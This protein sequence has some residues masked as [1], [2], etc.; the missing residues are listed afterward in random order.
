[1]KETIAWILAAVW[2]AAFLV[3]KVDNVRL[4]SELSKIKSFAHQQEV[5]HAKKLA[6]A[7]DSIL[8]A[9]REYDAVRSERDVLSRKLLDATRGS[10]KADTLGTCQRRVADLESL[11]GQLHGMVEKCDAGWHG[12]AARKDALS[13]VIK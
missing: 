8:V 1:M 4:D 5:E 11:V 2:A 10:S 7:T 13:E 3:V 9:S 6:T 12:C